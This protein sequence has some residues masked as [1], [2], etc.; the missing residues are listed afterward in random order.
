MDWQASLVWS[1]CRPDPSL[2][3]VA[4]NENEDE[5]EDE[6]NHL[7]GF[8]SS[9]T[10]PPSPTEAEFDRLTQD[11]TE[12]HNYD[13]IYAFFFDVN[14]PDPSL[15]VDDCLKAVH[16]PSHGWS[17][18]LAHVACTSDVADIERPSQ[19]V[20]EDLPAQAKAIVQTRERTTLTPE[21]TRVT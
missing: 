21:Q 7:S 12:G 13:D 2:D 6:N 17:Y 14:G 19:S 1:F 5:N 10:P 3:P 11:P 18:F 15:D 16:D 9:R 8:A 4:E 20:A